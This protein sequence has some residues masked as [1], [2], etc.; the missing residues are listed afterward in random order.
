MIFKKT[1]RKFNVRYNDP[2][3]KQVV[4]IS[5]ESTNLV[6]LY[7]KLTHKE[8]I[9]HKLNFRVTEPARGLILTRR[10]LSMRIAQAELTADA[11][12]YAENL[13]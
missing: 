10:Q 7:L 4:I 2:V 6:R 9:T 12:L 3:T 1:Y 13:N 5:I 11:F 8:F